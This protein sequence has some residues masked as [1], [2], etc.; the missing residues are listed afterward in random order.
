MQASAVPAFPVFFSMPPPGLNL[1]SQHWRRLLRRDLLA[2]GVV[3][4][5]G[6][7]KVLG[8]FG[9]ELPLSGLMGLFLLV[10]VAYRLIRLLG[11]ARNRLLWSLRNRLIVAYVLIAVV[12]VLLVAMAGLSAYLVYSQLGAYL[13]DDD[14]GSALERQRPPLKPWRLR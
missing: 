4:L 6:G 14:I 2:V 7:V 12:P 10:A 3:L 9:W 8:V 13:L 1:L 5:Y 11:W